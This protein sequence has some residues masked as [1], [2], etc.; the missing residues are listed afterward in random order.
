MK[1]YIIGFALAVFTLSAFYASAQQPRL[2]VPQG[3]TGW[4]NIQGGTLLV[5]TGSQ[6]RIAT[7]STTTL[8]ATSPLSLSQPVLK[9]GGSNSVLTISTTTNS[10]FTGTPGQVLAYTTSGWTGVATTT[11]TSPLSFSGGAVSVAQ[12]AA[13]GST[14]GVSTY[15]ASHFNSSLGVITIDFANGTEASAGVDGFL[16]GTDWSTFNNKQDTITAG[17]ALTLTGTD[18]DFDGGATP[19]GDLGGTWASPS[20]TDNSHAHDATTISGLGTADISGLDVSD[21]LNLTAGDALTLTGDDIDFDGGTA[22]GGSL[23]GTWA[24]PT[25]DDLFLLNTGDTGTGSYSLTFASTTAFSSAYSSSTDLFGSGLAECSDAGDTLNWNAGRFSCGSDAEGAGGAYP[26][27]PQAWNG[28]TTSATTSPLWARIGLMASSTSYFD[29]ATT[30]QLSI[31]S[32]LYGDTENILYFG[33]PATENV[34]TTPA[35]IAA[36]T[37]G[38]DFSLAAG[39]AAGT[40]TGGDFALV[41]GDGGDDTGA[42]G[43]VIIQGGSG[44]DTSGPGGAL[45]L[46]GGSA[47]AGD[48]NGGDV[49]ITAGSKSGGG[50]AG[51]LSLINEF[52]TF[53]SAAG[54]G[55]ITLL[56]SWDFGGAT[57]LE[58]PNNGTV[59]ANGEITT[60]DTT[61]QLRY[62]AGSAERV[63]VAYYTT[64]VSMASS[65]WGAGTTTLSLAPAPAAI[66]VQTVQCETSA[67]SLGVSLYDGTNRANYV[68]ASTTIGTFTY[69]SNNAFT[70]GESMRV[71]IGTAASSPK[72]IGCRFKYVYTAD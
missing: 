62:F 19:A 34:I 18:I 63:H 44:G 61:G 8:T 25:I 11:F 55:L 57:S 68:S 24:S 40:G 70:A 52:G 6:L 22:P 9:V 53:L 28:T 23:G 33:L 21:D 26:F 39:D 64:G 37:G 60:D 58:I 27:L 32:R 51:V 5:G 29:N 56:G 3:G 2:T 14:F 4:G 48:S 59:N 47:N 1:K 45:T 38:G 50:T 66:T 43:S 69:S 13:D 20:V 72:W 7:T 46:Q 16:S 67:G 10:L 36:D 54:T 17:D 49:S 15:N 71:D 31:T 30:S 42:G 65:T 12:A 35:A 41:A